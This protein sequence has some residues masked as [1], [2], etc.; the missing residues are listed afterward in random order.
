MVRRGVDRNRA[1]A[2]VQSPVADQARFCAGESAR[3]VVS[4]VCCAPGDVPNTHF[5]HLSAEELS[6]AVG[7]EI[8]RQANQRAETIGGTASQ[9]AVHVHLRDRK[10]TPLNSSH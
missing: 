5:I 2:F 4:N 1:D 7:A 8:Q 10:S 3:E 9:L 6:A